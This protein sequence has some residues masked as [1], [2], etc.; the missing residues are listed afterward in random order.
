M[1][2]REAYFEG[3]IRDFMA[4]LV[5]GYT[6]W[7]SG[8][9][10]GGV[11]IVVWFILL[12]LSL[13]LA[14]TSLGASAFGLAI[15]V[16]SASLIDVLLRTQGSLAVRIR[17][18]GIV[19]IAVCLVYFIGIYSFSKILTP[20]RLGRA[21][22][23]FNADDVVWY[24]PTTQCKLGE[25][26]VYNAPS[27]RVTAR[28]VERNQ[29]VQILVAGI[30]INRVFAKE[31]QLLRWDGK[32]LFVENQPQ[33]SPLVEMLSGKKPF[34]MKIPA[35][36]VF[37]EAIEYP[38]AGYRFVEIDYVSLG[39]IPLENILGPVRFRSYPTFSMRWY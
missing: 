15:A 16:H 18:T 30:R 22:S 12:L 33:E 39:L 23:V 28:W 9:R 32:Q 17:A 14:G 10:G 34:E 11:W 21:A 2:G 7:R 31:G 35:G 19:V 1:H 6:Q 27:K 38:E 37:V 3:S 29:N 25:Y 5:C 20:L 24:R 8:T 4:L 36:C 13:V 26:V